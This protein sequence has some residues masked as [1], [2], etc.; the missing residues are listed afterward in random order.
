ME[1]PPRASG[2]EHFSIL[3]VWMHIKTQ[4][5][6]YLKC[7]GI[8]GIVAFSPPVQ[9]ETMKTIMKT[10]TFEYDAAIQSGSFE[11]ATI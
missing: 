9:T 8:V 6:F 3:D 11:N 7:N 10:Q 2:I 1:V 5:H 4:M